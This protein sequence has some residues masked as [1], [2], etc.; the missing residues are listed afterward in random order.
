MGGLVDVMLAQPQDESGRV[1]S[2]R[3]LAERLYSDGLEVCV[4]LSGQLVEQLKEAF[5]NGETGAY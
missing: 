1:L 2:E 4:T 5:T 3:E